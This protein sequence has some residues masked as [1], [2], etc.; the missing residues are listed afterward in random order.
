MAKN[1][2]PSFIRPCKSRQLRH[3]G[4]RFIGPEQSDNIDINGVPG[5]FNKLRDELEADEAD[6][7]DE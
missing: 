3:G 1:L 6:D 7:G 4:R 5:V 2:A